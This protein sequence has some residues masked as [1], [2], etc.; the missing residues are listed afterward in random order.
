M[1]A[2]FGK[3]VTEISYLVGI[4]VLVLG[5]GPLFWNPFAQILG[6]RPVVS[7]SWSTSS[8]EKVVK[9]R[10]TASISILRRQQSLLLALSGV[11]V[12]DRMGPWLVRAFSSLSA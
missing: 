6:R 8:S 7:F 3:S 11:R 12:P 10:L 2:Q 5:A 4:Y 1:S 9:A